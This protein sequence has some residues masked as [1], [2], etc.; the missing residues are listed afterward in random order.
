MPSP[1]SQLGPASLLHHRPPDLSGH[2]RP[3]PGRPRRPGPPP[4]RHSSKSTQPSAAKHRGGPQY[5][6]TAEPAPA[7]NQRKSPAR[8]HRR[9]RESR[10]WVVDQARRAG[11]QTPRVTWPRPARP[12]TS[13][14]SSSQRRQGGHFHHHGRPRQYLCCAAWPAGR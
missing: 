1:S 7:A 10:C 13:A 8:L 3:A 5:N 4:D 14:A 11:G 12:F 6:A 9:R 2:T